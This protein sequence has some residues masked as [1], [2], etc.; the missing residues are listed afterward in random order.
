MPGRSRGGELDYGAFQDWAG[1]FPAA[2][3]LAELERVV[4]FQDP[5]RAVALVRSCQQPTSERGALIRTLVHRLPSC[6]GTRTSPQRALDRSAQRVTGGRSRNGRA[7]GPQDGHRDHDDRTCSESLALDACGGVSLRC[8]PVRDDFL[9]L[10]IELL[11][12]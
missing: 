9:S 4:A 1:R 6:R 2:E 8:W 5:S 7:G 12:R 3:L 10:T 11:R